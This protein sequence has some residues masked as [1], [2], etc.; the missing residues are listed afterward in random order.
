MKTLKTMTVAATLAAFFVAAAM[1][2]ASRAATEQFDAGAAYA[3]KCVACH[4]PKAAKKFDAA[5]ADAEH[6]QIVLKGKKGEKPPNMPGYEDKGVTEDQAKALVTY[7]RSI[8]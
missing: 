1:V 8:L 6:V 4:G 5:K 3:T 2:S 7:M